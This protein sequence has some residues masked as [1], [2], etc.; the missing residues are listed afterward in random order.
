MFRSLRKFGRGI[1]RTAKKGFAHVKH[2]VQKGGKALSSEIKH[3]VKDLYKDVKGTLKDDFNSLKHPGKLISN[4]IDSAQKTN[5]NF[6]LMTIGAIDKHLYNKIQPLYSK[7]LQHGGELVENMTGG[8]IP[9]ASLQ[10]LASTAANHAKEALAGKRPDFKKFIHNA[11]DIA[12]NYAANIIHE[13]LDEHFNP[14]PPP[15]SY[16]GDT[17]S[18][19][20]SDGFAQ[21]MNF[22]APPKVSDND[23][24]VTSSTKASQFKNISMDI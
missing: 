20:P 14:P 16:S 10:Q 5:G 12:K 17:T 24:N 22:E 23:S 9:A 15:P 13:K 1:K 19:D 6:A 7:V 8:K 2:K 3:H 18:W 11:S 21:S 4:V